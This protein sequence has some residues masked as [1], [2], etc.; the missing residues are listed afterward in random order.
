MG[1]GWLQTE[2]DL[3]G[4]RDS[5]LLFFYFNCCSS[6]IFG[7]LLPSQP[8]HPGILFLK[9]DISCVV[10][11]GFYCPRTSNYITLKLL[12]MWSPMIFLDW[13]LGK[14][15][16]QGWFITMKQGSCSTFC[17]GAFMIQHNSVLLEQGLCPIT[18]SFILA[19]EHLWSFLLTIFCLK[20]R[21]M[22]WKWKWRLFGWQADAHTTEPHQS[23]L[24]LACALTRDQTCNL[25]SKKSPESCRD[26]KNFTWA[27]VGVD[28]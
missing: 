8:T 4:W 16:P 23:C 3:R 27:L 15:V 10:L 1:V 9:G 26:I 11:A 12:C 21:H 17:T 24:S 7:L 6:T 20:S 28:H 18:M 2:I 14:G 5:I 19:L 13:P 25:V 22:L